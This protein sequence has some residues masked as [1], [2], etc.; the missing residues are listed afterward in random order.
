MHCIPLTD[1]EDDMHRMSIWIMTLVMGGLL[2]ATASSAQQ[3]EP[4]RWRGGEGGGWG[5]GGHYG[6]MYNPQ[7]VET[8]S[9]E[10]VKVERMTPRRG[11]SGGVHVLVQTATETIPVH[12]GPRWFLENQDLALAPKEQV[13]VRG[14]RITFNGK[15]AIIAAEVRKGEHVLKLRDDQGIPAW[16]GWRRRG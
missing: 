8:I 11:M 5:P 3:G 16:S 15:P 12:L 1:M 2:L 10:V 4:W 14:S 13:E 9:G 7:T 6:R